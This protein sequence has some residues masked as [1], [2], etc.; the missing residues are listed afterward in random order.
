M[1][2]RF[3][4]N[5]TIPNLLTGLRIL[6]MPFVAWYLWQ[7]DVER[8]FWV[9]VV[10]ALTDLLDGN[11]A[12]L[13]KQRT[14]LGAWL[15]PIADKLMLLTTLGM[16]CLTGL[17]PL[18]LL[19]TVLI[20]DGVILA[21][22][23]GYRRLT[24]GLDVRPTISGKLATAMEFILISFTLADL[25]LHLGLDAWIPPL[26]QATAAMVTLSGLRYVWLWSAKTRAYL[27][28]HAGRA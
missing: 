13:L 23:E 10:A 28:E 4:R 26:A 25:A 2:R 15:D 17:L 19:W 5:W 27:R 14:V 11:L 3:N 7:G 20:R 16:L 1:N 18:W 8:A 12:R 21:G 6:L 22:A 9:F 24:G